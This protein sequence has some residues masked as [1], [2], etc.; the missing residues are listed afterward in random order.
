[1]QRVR[2]ALEQHAM[3]IRGSG[4]YIELV[5]LYLF[6]VYRHMEPSIFFN[7]KEEMKAAMPLSKLM[8]S[9]L[10]EE[11]TPELLRYI[12]A[13]QDDNGNFQPKGC[14]W[15]VVLTRADFVPTD[16]HGEWNHWAVC[17]DCSGTTLS[18]RLDFLKNAQAAMSEELAS[19]LQGIDAEDDAAI[20]SAVF[21]QS[22]VADKMQHY[23]TLTRRVH[24]AS[25]LFVMD[26]AP[27]GNC[28][29]WAL[30]SLLEEL[31]REILLQHVAVPHDKD[32][33]Y[34]EMMRMR[35]DLSEMWFEVACSENW[36]KFFSMML[37]QWQGAVNAGPKPRA[38]ENAEVPEPSQVELPSTKDAKAAGIASQVE[39]PSSVAPDAAPSTPTRTANKF[40]AEFTPPQVA[41]AARKVPRGGILGPRTA[42]VDQF[43]LKLSMPR[44]S[45]TDQVRDANLDLKP[46]V[47]AELKVKEEIIDDD[48]AEKQAHVPASIE[49]IICIFKRGSD[50]I[51]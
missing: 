9:L 6:S 26:V 10:G 4:V 18:D 23:Q 34:M 24:E 49:Q 22:R 43:K 45:L 48:V 17:R 38:A 1:M 51:R 46:S 2:T 20:A 50:D 27:D 42:D 14:G 25:G 28:G 15:G 16:N 39:L 29:V 37:H 31:T 21:E 44:A 7:T 5:D 19:V 13:P 36:C 47:N 33:D 8:G 41:P 30:K 35:V 40:F 3:N 12:A 11:S 32:T